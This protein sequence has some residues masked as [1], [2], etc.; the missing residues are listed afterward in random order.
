MHA[1]ANPAKKQ[2][3]IAATMVAIASL[4]TEPLQ[5]TNHM[6]PTLARHWAT[7]SAASAKWP[8]G[9]P[10]AACPSGLAPPLPAGTA[11]NLQLS[12]QLQRNNHLPRLHPQ[13]GCWGIP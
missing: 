5:P 1:I 3:A 13:S 8:P 9:L 7:H 6:E 4:N 11:I 2:Y 12:A 10:E